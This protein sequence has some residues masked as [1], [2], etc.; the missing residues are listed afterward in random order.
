VKTHQS[1]A[2]VR[3]ILEGYYVDPKTRGHAINAVGETGLN[4]RM[5]SIL[6]LGAFVRCMHRS[7]NRKVFR[8]FTRVI[9]PILET[10]QSAWLTELLRIMDPAGHGDKAHLTVELCHANFSNDVDFSHDERAQEKAL[11]KSAQAAY[12]S[13]GFRD[14]RNQRMFHLALAENLSLPQPS[15]DMTRLSSSLCNWY[16][17]VAC[18][19]IG[20][21][22]RFVTETAPRGGRAQAMAIKRLFLDSLRWQAA[23]GPPYR[24]SEY[25]R[26]GW[27][28]GEWIGWLED[29]LSRGEILRRFAAGAW[30]SAER[31][32]DNAHQPP[33]DADDSLEAPESKM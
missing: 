3:E 16:R 17:F 14:F 22:P 4:S 19:T 7:I 23:K 31:S 30:A 25:N 24:A 26:Y 13:N 27:A 28:S 1:K 18:A 32:L 6:F 10:A 15:G 33:K 20:A 11:F 9:A 8:Y 21:E 12:E 2:K 29:G 5:V